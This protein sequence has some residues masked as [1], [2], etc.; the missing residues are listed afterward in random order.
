MK[1]IM[2]ALLDEVHYPIPQ[3]FVENVIIKRGLVEDENF[4]KSVADSNAYKGALADCL[5]S[6]VQSINFSESD[7][8][9]GALTDEQRKAIMAQ[10]KKLYS[11]I[12]EDDEILGLQPIVYV[13]S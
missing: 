13:M 3:G 8:S 9:I 10:A 5:Y 12:G 6:L 11:E 1:T 7:K 2:Q 4:S